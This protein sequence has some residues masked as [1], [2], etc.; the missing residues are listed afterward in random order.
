MNLKKNN[1][2]GSAMLD[3]CMWSYELL[4]GFYYSAFRGVTMFRDET[5]LEGNTQT[6][7]VHVLS[8]IQNLSELVGPSLVK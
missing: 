4:S 8:H 1:S 2:L 5:Q 7:N 6:I 3:S